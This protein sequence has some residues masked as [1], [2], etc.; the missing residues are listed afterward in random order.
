VLDRYGEH[1]VTRVRLFK[2]PPLT[3]GL[4]VPHEDM[5]NILKDMFRTY[6]KVPFVAIHKS[7]FFAKEEV[8]AIEDVLRE[9]SGGR[10]KPGLLALHIKEDTIYKSFGDFS[11]KRGALLVDMLKSNRAILFTTGRIG[12]KERRRLGTPRALELSVYTNTLSLDV[13]M[14]AEQVLAL[15]KLDWNTTELEIR[16]PITLKYSHKAA[17]LAPY[18]LSEDTEDLRV[19]DIRDLM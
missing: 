10:V 12:E 19:G 6:G 1:L 8:R 5:Y 4:Y 14:I 9:Y 18:M 2:K 3:R 16:K 15:T 13:K 7:S 17:R 11:I